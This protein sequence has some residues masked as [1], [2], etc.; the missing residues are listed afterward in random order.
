MGIITDFINKLRKKSAII[1][2]PI[3]IITSDEIISGYLEEEEQENLKQKVERI[4]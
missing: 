1:K 4:A 2:K 3:T